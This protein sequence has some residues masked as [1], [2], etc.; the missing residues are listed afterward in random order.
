MKFPFQDIFK[1]NGVHRNGHTNGSVIKAAR[2]DPEHA[3][4]L[5]NFSRPRMQRMYEAAITTNLNVDYPISIASADSEI[6]SSLVNGR[7]RAR[8]CER[9][10]PYAKSV[11][12]TWLSNAGGHEPFRLE[13]NVGKWVGE[14]FVR[15]KE[16]N[17]KIEDWWKEMGRPEN[18]TVRRNITRLELYVQ[19]IASLIRDGGILFRHHRLFKKNRFGY[20]IEPLETDRLDPSYNSANFQPGK[21]GQIRFSIEMDEFGA[22]EAYWLLARHPGDY[23]AW[24]NDGKYRERVPAENIIA[25]FDFRTRAEQ[26]IGMP[27]LASIL[28]H[29]HQDKQ[30]DTAH[31]AA[32][33]FAA[34]KP[35]FI[36]RNFPTAMEVVPDY[37][38]NLM[39]QGNDGSNPG[40]KY[41]SIEPAQVQVLEFGE[42]AQMLDPKFP[43]ESAAA[44]KKDRLRAVAAGS[45]APYFQIANDLE[46]VNFSS[47][48]LGLEAF[49]DEVKMMQQLIIQTLCVP[50]FEIAIEYAILSGGLDLP[51]GRLQEYKQGARFYGRRWPYIQPLQDAQA[52]EVRL[53]IGT[54]SR[55]EIRLESDGGGDVEDLDSKIANEQEADKAHGLDFTHVYGPKNGPP[56][57]TSGNKP[58]AQK[59]QQPGQD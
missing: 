33:T 9:D 59:I 25:L 11:I 13:S 34:C 19:T 29:L 30:F 53:R 16:I 44:F 49:H 48:R 46:S 3:A 43:M 15:D 52:D 20:A 47:G 18:C 27:R 8:T 21:P 38:K 10:N 17:R 56:D 12:Q 57:L 54:V 2:I 26:S 22:P 28:Q 39:T 1:R 4:I 36:K 14:K 41:Q 45:G 51:I 24:N 37:I 31:V 6:Q 35:M 7:A 32:A 40:E 58:D 55:E 42:E 23:F 5:R 50:H